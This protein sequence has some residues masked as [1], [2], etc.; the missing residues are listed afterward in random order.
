MYLAPGG[1]GTGM[2]EF[3][4]AENPRT[5]EI[6]PYFYMEHKGE[7]NVYRFF[8]M[9]F[10]QAGP[11]GASL[12]QKAAPFEFYVL[13]GRRLRTI[14]QV[15]P[16]RLFVPVANGGGRRTRGPP[17]P[18][19]ESPRPKGEG[20]GRDSVPLPPLPL[21]NPHPPKL[22]EPCSGSSGGFISFFFIVQSSPEIVRDRN[23]PYSAFEYGLIWADRRV[24]T[25]RFLLAAVRAHFQ[26]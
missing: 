22:A 6:I 2:C 7:F 4:R 3:L 20:W 11:V 13:R 25:W 26:S 17:G 19:C 9:Y 23:R 1:S 14:M 21:W 10:V 16:A 12:V 24:G 5:K 8:T 18:S 15:E